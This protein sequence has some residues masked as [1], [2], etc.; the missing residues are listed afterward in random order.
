M[1]PDDTR[2]RVLEYI[3][4][5]V[6]ANG[7]GPTMREI[8]T[9]CGLATSSGAHYHVRKLQAAGILTSRRRSPRTVRPT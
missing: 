1:K 5:F 2:Q 8:A 9:A 3:T 4:A 7:Y 6:D